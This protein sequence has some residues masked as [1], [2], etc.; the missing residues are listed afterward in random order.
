MIKFS[1]EKHEK[2]EKDNSFNIQK[3]ELLNKLLKEE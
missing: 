1:L 2:I 3:K